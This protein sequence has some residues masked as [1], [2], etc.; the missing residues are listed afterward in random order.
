MH[1]SLADIFVRR[2]VRDELDGSKRVGL[3][4]QTRSIEVHTGQQTGAGLH[5]VFARH[6]R[7]SRCRLKLR[8]VFSRQ[9]ERLLQGDALN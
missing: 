1:I 8:A 6:T 4:V 7:I 2:I 9:V 3:R 5:F